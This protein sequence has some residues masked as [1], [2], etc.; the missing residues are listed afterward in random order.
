[1]AEFII[2]NWEAL[3]AIVGVLLTAISTLLAVKPPRLGGRKKLK[4]DLEIRTLIKDDNEYKEYN[5]HVEREIKAAFDDIYR[6]G[7]SR[8]GS[9]GLR[10][11]GAVFAG[12]FGWASYAVVFK[13]GSFDFSWWVLL[14]GYWTL[15]GLGLLIDP[16]LSEKLKDLATNRKQA[17]D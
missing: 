3:T 6:R 17:H 1:M 5:T 10:I 16:S 7:F 14:T 15:V 11:T 8:T 2:A 9:I 12:L 4:A 13:D